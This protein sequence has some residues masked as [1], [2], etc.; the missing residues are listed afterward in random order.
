MSIYPEKI[1]RKI[2]DDSRPGPPGDA[3]CGRSA[4]FSCGC[5]SEAAIAVNEECQTIETLRFA[6]NGCGFMAA[7]GRVLEGELA[8]KVLAE[9]Y[10]L[11]DAALAAKIEDEL[12]EFPPERKQCASVAIEAL[13]AAFTNYRNARACEFVG[14]SPLICSCFGVSEDDLLAAIRETGASEPKGLGRVTRAG[15]GCG[16]CRMLIEEL[17]EHVKGQA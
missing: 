11:S 9:L 2:F 8:G 7:S 14:D 17:I 5:F 4:S 13:K 1:A 6:T 15:S 10:G 12:G 3:I 16:A